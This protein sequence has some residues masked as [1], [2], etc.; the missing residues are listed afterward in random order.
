MT[1]GTKKLDATL[2]SRKKNEEKV[3]DH[4]VFDVGLY[5]GLGSN[6]GEQHGEKDE[7]VEEAEDHREHEDLGGFPSTTW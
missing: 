4:L 2:A 5:L 7:T 3:G 1:S 6:E